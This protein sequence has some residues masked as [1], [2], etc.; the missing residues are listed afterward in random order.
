MQAAVQGATSVKNVRPRTAPGAR[1]ESRDMAALY[2]RRLPRPSTS[3]ASAGV[4]RVRRF[5]TLAAMSDLF[6]VEVMGREARSVR[7][8]LRILSLDEVTFPLSPGFAR[9]LIEDEGGSRARTVSRRRG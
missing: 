1:P 9:M 6:R 7:L 4:D 5:S 2:E 8:R 3:T